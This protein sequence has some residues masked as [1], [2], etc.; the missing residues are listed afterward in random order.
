MTI[1]NIDF[2]RRLKGRRVFSLRVFMIFLI[3]FS[4]FVS[5]MKNRRKYGGQKFSCNPAPC[6]RL[7]GSMDG[8]LS[9]LFRA[10]QKGVYLTDTPARPK[11]RD[12]LAGVA[13]PASLGLPLSYHRRVVATKFTTSRNPSSYL[14]CTSLTLFCKVFSCYADSSSIDSR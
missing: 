14:H 2:C 11:S 12:S 10:Q 9:F 7:T 1:G 4:S 8:F 5:G 13:S 6:G 3:A